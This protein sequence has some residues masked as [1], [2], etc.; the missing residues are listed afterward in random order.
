MN[1]SKNVHV[2]GLSPREQYSL[3]LVLGNLMTG[4]IDK[5]IQ[6]A[7][8]LKDS[9]SVTEKCSRVIGL[10]NRYNDF[11]DMLCPGDMIAKC[12]PKVLLIKPQLMKYIVLAVNGYDTKNNYLGT[13]HRRAL[14]FNFSDLKKKVLET[15]QYTYDTAEIE[16]A[17]KG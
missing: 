5:S 7:A 1:F 9:E 8:D 3:R 6:E 14:D 4:F 12:K 17:K 15:S 10:F 16:K 13:E 11:I 2:L